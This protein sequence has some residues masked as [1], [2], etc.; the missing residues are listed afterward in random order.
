[1]E[2]KTLDHASSHKEGGSQQFRI[3]Q[4]GK[5]FLLMYRFSHFQETA[6]KWETNAQAWFEK[7]QERRNKGKLDTAG[8]D[9][10]DEEADIL[11]CEDLE[12]T[13]CVDVLT[14]LSS[15]RNNGS[16]VTLMQQQIQRH[17]RELQYAT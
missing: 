6:L 1:M 17:I 10:H 11:V 5:Y 3:Y 15:T 13:Y 9:Q 2:V 7:W 16:C 14:E 8:S 4:R 12:S